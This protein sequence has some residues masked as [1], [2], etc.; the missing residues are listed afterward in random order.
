MISAVIGEIVEVGE[1]EVILRTS[2]GIELSVVIS[3][4]SVSKLSNLRKEEVRLFT[5]LQVR[6]D[7]MLLYGFTDEEERRL[8][9]ELIKVSGI[10]PRQAMRILSGSQVRA[11]IRALDANDI[12][13]LSSIPGIGPKTSQKI[14]L[15]LRGKIVLDEDD[16][17]LGERVGTLD[18]THN[19][20]VVALCDM[21]Y[22]RRQVVTT[23]RELLEIHKEALEG[24]N[25]REQEE[26]LFKNMIIRLG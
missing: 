7:S 13:Y 23:L 8:F 9:L 3:H 12:K 10:G 1:Q 6:E 25:N 19:D 5:S 4:Q 16:G 14:V 26:F 24:L 18:P 11:F 20:L 17:V 2:I 15:A 22:D 21:G